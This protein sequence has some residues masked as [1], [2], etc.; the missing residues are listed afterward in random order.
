MDYKTACSLY[1]TRYNREALKRQQ[2]V[3]KM[4]D[5]EILLEFSIIQKE[6]SETY[7]LL[8]DTQTVDLVLNQY[9]YVVGT[10]ASNIKADILDID[11][12]FMSPSLTSGVGAQPIFLHKA[13]IQDIAYTLKLSGQPSRYAFVGQDADS[14]LWIN[15]LPIGYSSDSTSRLFIQYNRKLYL[16]YDNANNDNTTWSDYDETASDYGGEFKIPNQF[17]SLIVEGALAN[18]FPELLDSYLFKVNRTVKAKPQSVSGKLQYSLGGLIPQS[19]I[20]FGN[21]N[22]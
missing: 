12:I 13:S 21:N 19:Q 8:T 15:T 6:L 17:H 5:R 11:A 2:Q 4:N 14:V 16:F 1:R 9:Q 10:G 18:A 22:N 20:T 7:R 3:P